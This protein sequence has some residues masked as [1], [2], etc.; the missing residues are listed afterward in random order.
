MAAV[1][2]KGL[3][4]EGYVVTL[5][6]DGPTGLSFAQS[7]SFDG[8]VLDVMLPGYDGFEMARRLR[9]ASNQ[10]PILFLTARDAI[11]DVVTGLDLGGDDYLSKPF[12]FEILLA[13]VRALTRRGAA[14]TPVQLQIAD[15][16]LD[17][18]TRE[19]TRGG[20][21]ITLTRRE[22]VLLE[23]LM[24]NK[25]RVVDRSTLIDTVWGSEKDIESNTL[26][27]FIRLLRSKVDRAHTPKLIQTVRGVG[28]CIRVEP[29]AHSS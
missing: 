28:Y 20:Q 25:E 11:S 29:E 15:L 26:D 1:L 5:A 24:R 16:V 12:S 22:F 13:R 4:E 3:Q 9:R 27:V 8:I 19:V 10:T 18:G 2:C 17:S 23:A 21:R 7:S 6:P 14:P